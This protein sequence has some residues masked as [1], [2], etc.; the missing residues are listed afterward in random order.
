MHEEPIPIARRRIAELLRHMGTD[1]SRDVVD[2]LMAGHDHP[3]LSD[4]QDVALVAFDPIGIQDMVLASSR[5]TTIRGASRGLTEWDESL[6]RG[7]DLHMPWVPLFA[8]GGQGV[9]LGP[10]RLAEAACH[11]L[12]D[13]F[14]KRLMA[15][16]SAAFIPVS[17]RE[18]A[19]GPRRWSGS[20]KEA[21]LRLLGVNM[22]GGGGFGALLGRLSLEL[23]QAKDARPTWEVDG[24]DEVRCCECGRRAASERAISPGDGEFRICRRC[25]EF[26]RLGG[27]TV[28]KKEARSLDD[29]PGGA[30]YLAIDG[31]GIGAELQRL[32]SL[33]QYVAMSHALSQ[34]FGRSTVESAL[35]NTLG[36]STEDRIVAIAGG[37]DVVL[38]VGAGVTT[39]MVRGPVEVAL[40]LMR[41]IDARVNEQLRANWPEGVQVP[42]IGAGA[43][44]LVARK[45]SAR[46]G[47]KLARDL[48]RS[49]KTRRDHT[50]RSAVDFEYVSGASLA[51]SSI[52][53]LRKKR[54]RGWNPPVVAEGKASQKR[55]VLRYY[56]RPCSFEELDELLRISKAAT[57]ETRSLIYRVRSALDEDPMLGVVT[58]AYLLRNRK[59][60]ALPEGTIGRSLDAVDTLLLRKEPAAD[61]KLDV[62]SSAIPDVADL[63]SVAR[64]RSHRRES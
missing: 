59:G 31:A 52:E 41:E 58:G 37:D 54:E 39:E 6:E 16:C 36:V 35:A 5:P 40:G 29:L 42:A 2:S 14:A 33:H 22:K 49:A 19:L 48:V 45:L 28:A 23:A 10:A 64:I 20:G 17:T 1:S 32:T 7:D 62:W 25:H 27:Q 51:A 18:L 57:N 30:A 26:H 53:D 12:E 21:A 8:G 34:G 3:N 11:T 44:V 47:F 46:T 38:A 63:L 61:Q 24:H 13:A 50:V 4:V 9:F 56:R 15:P 55:G 43:G 60:F